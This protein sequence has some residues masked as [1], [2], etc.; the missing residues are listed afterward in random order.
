MLEQIFPQ[1]NLRIV[2]LADLIRAKVDV[3]L[4]DSLHTFELLG[5]RKA[6]KDIKKFFYHHIATVMCDECIS[7]PFESG[8]CVFYFNCIEVHDLDLF[9]YFP[10]DEVVAE[11][12]RAISHINRIFPLKIHKDKLLF[13]RA[14][15][16]I[17]L[18]SGEGIELVFE[19]KK[20]VTDGNDNYNFAKVVK[21]T[22]T[23]ELNELHHRLTSFSRHRLML[24]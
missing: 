5:K 6:T 24:A 18:G 9:N 13:D 2:N 4:V 1:H 15:N 8:K 23:E 3:M 22:L 19:L 14:M 10:K 11:I 12:K 17:S 20:L 7:T 21:H 16:Y